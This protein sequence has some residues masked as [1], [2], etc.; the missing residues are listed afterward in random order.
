MNNFRF[1]TPYTSRVLREVQQTSRP[2][3]Q[4]TPFRVQAIVFDILKNHL[5]LN[6]PKD[7]GFPF[8]ET[9]DPDP[10]KSKIFI[11][12]SNNWKT[13]APQKRPAAYVFR[14]EAEYGKANT[15]FIG[16]LMSSDPMTSEDTYMKIVT[17]PIVINCIH[18]PV[19]AA[20]SFA[21]YIKYPFLY[22]SKQIKEEYCFLKFKLAS[23]SPPEQN[24][25]DAKD[26]FNIK[27]II[28]TEFSDAWIVKKDDLK[29]KTVNTSVYTE[30]TEKPLQNQ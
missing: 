1:S 6:N 2:E 19:G 25:N 4:L 21:E 13:Q 30:L 16:E 15:N 29:L 28:E 17:M 23:V 9:Y 26:A 8:D 11:D 3:C 20:E 14:G 22:F 27:M 10:A 24:L 7:L 18:S 5:I 12:L